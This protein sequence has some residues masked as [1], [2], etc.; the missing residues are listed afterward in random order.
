MPIILGKCLGKSDLS[1]TTLAVSINTVPFPNVVCQSRSSV[2]VA[3]AQISIMLIIISLV[4]WSKVD[5]GLKNASKY[6]GKWKNPRQF[7]M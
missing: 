3:L 2:I 5:M 6:V 7:C 4:I 1:G